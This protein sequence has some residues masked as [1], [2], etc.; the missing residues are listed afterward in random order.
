MHK[1]KSACASVTGAR[2]QLCI[3]YL[4]NGGFLIV[5]CDMYHLAEA[6]VKSFGKVDC[7]EDIKRQ[8]SLKTKNLNI[9]KLESA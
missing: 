8:L 7:K 9:H 6:K 5:Y 3:V 2:I 4:W 1:S